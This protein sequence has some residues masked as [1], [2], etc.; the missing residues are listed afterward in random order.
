MDPLPLSS[1]VPCTGVRPPRPL[2]GAALAWACLLAL[3]CG[4]PARAD[5]PA[6]D[7]AA[8][9][10][11]VE[12][13]GDGRVRAGYLARFGGFVQWPSGAFASADA[14]LVIGLIDADAVADDLTGIV[15]KHMP[16]GRMLVVR[17]LR[18]GDPVG[19]LHVLFIGPSVNGRLAEVLA[20]VR[21]A[22]ILIVTEHADA[23]AAGSTVNFAVVD[24]RLRFEVSLKS[25]A[26]AGLSISARLLSAAARVEPLP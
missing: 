7:P 21:S 10:D 5:H 25:A 18:V 13:P 8:D 22:P 12:A 26:R 1:A 6:A 16:Q 19:G 4:A 15:G 9:R 14:P 3:A 17:R 11:A 23:L 2:R 24:G 20:T